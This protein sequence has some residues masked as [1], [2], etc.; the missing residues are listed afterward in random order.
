MISQ[1]LT[2]GIQQKLLMK[3]LEFTYTIEYKQGVEN[4][5]ADAL[6]RKEQS[7]LA[8]STITPTW[9]SDI[10]HSYTNDKLYIELIQQL[11]I[12]QN[13]VPHY[14]VHSGILRYKGKICVGSNSDLKN[15]VL[16]SLHSSAI[17]VILV[18]ELHTNKSAKCPTCQI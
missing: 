6:S 15:K 3:L 16:S 17:G 8:I 1:R 18:L 5:V 14:S 9:I 2:E 12:D 10:E 4:R 7:I 13:V 11:L